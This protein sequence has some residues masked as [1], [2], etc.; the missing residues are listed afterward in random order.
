MFLLQYLALAIVYAGLAVFGSLV[1]VPWVFLRLHDGALSTIGPLMNVGVDG[2]N[3]TV[4]AGIVGSV[5]SWIA[6]NRTT[7]KFQV[8]AAVLIA[9]SAPIFVLVPMI[10][11][12]YW[13]AQAGTAWGDAPQRVWLAAAFAVYLLVMWLGLDEVTSVAHLFYRERLAT[14]FVGYRKV[15]SGDGGAATLGYAQPPWDEDLALSELVNGTTEEAKLPN[16]VVCAAVNLSSDLPVGRMGASFTFERDR[17]GG[18]TTGYVPTAWMEARAGAGVATLPA[19]MAISGAAVAPSMGKM[20]IRALRFLMAVF[21]LRLGVWLPNPATAP[22]RAT[23]RDL[24]S[25]EPA[26]KD[27]A[28]SEPSFATQ[29]KR[30]GALYVFREAFGMNSIRRSFAYVTD[31]G[32]WEN[33]GLVE[34]LRRGCSRI[35]CIDGSGGDAVTFGTLSEAIALARSDLGVEISIDLSGM[36]AEKGELSASGFAFGRIEFPDGTDGTL[37]YVRALLTESSP[38]D[39][40]SYGGKDKKFPN[41]PTSDQFF[42][43]ERFEAYRALGQ[44]LMQQA[45]DC[46]AETVKVPKSSSACP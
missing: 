35:V 5:A 6:K 23:T 12:A 7:R 3:L 17:V 16:L 4:M 1:A 14:A 26:V 2:V 41:H 15:V 43:E 18:P 36:H 8:V 40:R 37:V 45:I 27:L 44:Y 28:A 22:M 9:L 19:L 20:T 30:P 33:L 38:E 11:V 32:H 42:D 39:L 25:K 34:L 10:G 21:D 24:R 31:G 46:H 29:W 13:N